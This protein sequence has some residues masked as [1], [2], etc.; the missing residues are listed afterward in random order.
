MNGN[1]ERLLRAAIQDLAGDPH[2]PPD[3][4]SVVISRGRRI[5]R[6][7]RV[8]AT[9]A[10]LV[11]VAAIAAPY[12]WLRPVERSPAP[13]AAAPS[14]GTDPEPAVTATPT[15][16][17]TV[18]P[19]AENWQDGPLRLPG[20]WLLAGLSPRVI[21]AAWAY[22]RVA[23]RYVEL[24]RQ[25]KRVWVAP[26]GSMVAVQRSLTAPEIGVLNHATRQ[27]RWTALDGQV[28]DAQWSP[29]GTRLLINFAS[30]KPLYPQ[31]GILDA[32][33][34]SLRQYPLQPFPVTCAD[35]CHFSWLPN[36]REIAVPLL[37]R[38]QAPAAR[39]EADRGSP[40]PPSPGLRI[41]TADD[42][43]PSRTLPVSGTVRGPGAWSPDG[44]L[45]VVQAKTSAQLVEVATGTVVRKLPS[46]DVT[47]V[48]DD[49]L[50]YLAN[51]PDDC[52]AVLIDP[53]GTEIQR[54]PL[55]KPFFRAEIVVAPN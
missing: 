52:A 19:V 22:D 32:R 27:L 15:V 3:L 43:T 2:Q 26:Q 28:Y 51:Y 42:G 34:N 50:L 53:E 54:L 35:P 18:P 41:Y 48:R 14:T 11:A 31:F 1:E 37:D 36:G 4:V 6:R 38:G 44:R 49:R 5:R 45:V 9:A 40:T 33:T 8:A 10:A 25:Y 7:R 46:A 30:P 23:G 17:P 24:G 20:G 12:V 39:D 55:P 16:D 13:V 21:P 47:W 29:D